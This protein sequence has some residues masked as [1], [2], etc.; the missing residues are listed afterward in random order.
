M[1]KAKVSHLQETQ[2]SGQQ[3]VGTLLAAVLAHPDLPEK[4]YDG[5][6][7]ALNELQTR[8][9]SRRADSSRP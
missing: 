5:I 6:V 3:P 7:D 2:K 1:A 8:E 4:V 9:V